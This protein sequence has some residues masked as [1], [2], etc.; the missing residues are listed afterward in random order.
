MSGLIADS[1]LALI[2]G[3]L[4]VFVT[5]LGERNNFRAQRGWYVIVVSFG[6]M[7]L[8]SVLELANGL[9]PLLSTSFFQNIVKFGGG[10]VGGPLLLLIGLL[11]WAPRVATSREAH[12]MRIKT[13]ER[14]YRML[15]EKASDMLAEYDLEGRFLYV[16]P[17]AK[18][19][20]G[21]ESSELEGH[22]IYDFIHPDQQALVELEHRT[23]L[24]KN[25]PVTSVYKFRH[26]DGH[27]IWLESLAQT[28]NFG[29]LEN[30]KRILSMSR[31][32]S[33]RMLYEDA[34]R[35]LNRSLQIQKKRFQLLYEFST[36]TNLPVSEQLEYALQTTVKVLELDIGIIS[37]ID[38]DVYQI[39]HFFSES[40]DLK[41]EQVF[42]FHDTYCSITIEK[43]DVVAI[44]EMSNS[45]YAHHPCWNVFH[46]EAYIGVPILVKG[47]VY[48]TLTFSNVKARKAAFTEE[49]RDYIRLMGQWVSRVLEGEQANQ[50]LQQSEER[51][52]AVISSSVVG[53][54]LIDT[55]GLIRSFNSAAENI[56]GYAA[57]EVIG[58]SIRLL[59]Y[60]SDYADNDRSLK[61]YLKTQLP[62]FIGTTREVEAQTKSGQ[63]IHIE[64]GIS[65]II[66]GSQHYY[67]GTVMD[68]SAR[69]KAEMDLANAH[70]RLKNVFESAIQVAIIATDLDGKIT[71]FNPGA[72]RILGY[73]AEEVMGQSTQ[74]FHL[75]SEIAERAKMLSA[76]LKRPVQ[77]TDVFFTLAKLG[78]QSELEWTYVRKDGSFL[79]VSSAVTAL[80][81]TTG[82]ITGFLGIIL[83]ITSWKKAE[84]ALKLAKAV[85]EQANQTKS[86]FLANMSHEL[87]T[88]LNSVI[89]FSNILMQLS[90]QKLNENE[91]IYLERILS[92]GK[93]LLDLINDILDLSKIEAGKMDLEIV[94][95]NIGDQV[96]E[97]LGL[98]EDQ[99]RRKAIELKAIIPDDLQPNPIDPGKLKQILLNLISNAI[100][101]TE[102]G[103][104][105]IELIQNK[106]N[107]RVSEIRVS[108]TGIGIPEDRL[109]TIFDEFAQV[110]SSTQRK[111]GGTGLGLSISRRLCLLMGCQLTVESIADQGSTFIIRSIEQVVNKAGVLSVMRSAKGI[112][113]SKRSQEFPQGDYQGRRILIVDDD[114]DSRTLLSLYL[115]DTGC[116]LEIA[117]S[118]EAG[119]ASI[120]KNRP[121]LITLDL[122]MP[123]ISGEK[124]LKILQA[125]K[126]MKD[127]PVIIVSIIARDKR[128][129]LPGIVDYV[130]KPIHHQQLLWAVKRSM[131]QRNRRVILVEETHDFQNILNEIQEQEALEFYSAKNESVALEIVATM[132]PNLILVDLTLPG[133]N[134]QE[135]L[136]MLRSDME[137]KAVPV[138]AVAKET[139][140]STE[141]LFYKTTNVSLITKGPEF[142]VEIKHAVK[143]A[144]NH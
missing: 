79:T 29:N 96:K 144:L 67:S 31:D 91:N 131:R 100:K 77:G 3:L 56:F 21:Y 135:F 134:G 20:V 13:S 110:D 138:I 102:K 18:R 126:E 70:L 89:G 30:Q 48:G 109:K 81:D 63:V 106:Q 115:A 51:Y 113:K 92:N 139:L 1:L 80:Y 97:I 120:H 129:Q 99:T 33:D 40:V 82:T 128:G 10:Q 90:A 54:I 116:D 66:T 55:A 136:K 15:A 72:E 108:D 42:D 17:G 58:T 41:K 73:T 46:L 6:L 52:K 60:D 35:D 127:I 4:F 85:A 11:L 140:T 9:Y 117:Q 141:T 87:R 95:I 25:E 24:T 137:L 16:T 14:R 23:I 83:D 78:G 88:P 118:A 5:V 53:V 74:I 39:R 76:S 59:M 2:L 122:K 103:S 84:E 27:Y 45:E 104:V 114:D 65:E 37:S 47:K 124:F 86:E 49:D 26:R 125:D 132:I 28:Y 71:I 38:G 61:E 121:D 36:N 105:T 22:L 143:E 19:I 112:R 93:H 64:M 32:V 98:M 133:F 50:E 43:M 94:E 111:Y 119:F 34:L 12:L 7:W 75:E 142:K 130:Q 62:Q 123:K 57:E 44:D 8:G 69:K 101:F 68:I 107:H